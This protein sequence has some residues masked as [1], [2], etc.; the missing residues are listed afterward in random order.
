M[1]GK[2]LQGLG[3]FYSFLDFVLRIWSS[4][5]SLLFLAAGGNI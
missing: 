5:I 1:N 4:K 2:A 3:H